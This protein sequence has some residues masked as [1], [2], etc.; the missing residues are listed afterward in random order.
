MKNII[1]SASKF[2]V[3]AEM[4]RHHIKEEESKMLPKAKKADIDLDALGQEE[5]RNSKPLPFY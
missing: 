1:T 2:A 4:V 3:L 5:W